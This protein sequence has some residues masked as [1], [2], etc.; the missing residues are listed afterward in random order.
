M[1]RLAL[2]GCGGISHTH[3]QRFHIESNNLKVVAT[4]D[5]DEQAARTAQEHIGAEK[6]ATDY[7]EILDDVDA[8]LLAL[9]HHLHHP[10][11]LECLKAGKHVLMEKPLANTEADCLELI[12]AAEEHKVVL[13]VA[14]C[15]RYHP[16]LEKMHELIAAK[17]YGDTFHVSIWTEQFTKYADDHWAHK[18]ATVG[19]GQFFSHGCHYVDIL[20]LLLGE[21]ERGVH[22]GTNFGTPWMEKEGTSD[23]SITF[24]SGAVGYHGGT[25]GARGSRLGNAFHAHC[26]E[27]ML[28]ADIDGGELRLLRWGQEPEILLKTEECSKYM[29]REMHHFIDCI[30]NGIEPITDA[31]DSLQ[32]LRVVWK[33]YEAEEKHTMADLN[34]LGI[35]H[36]RNAVLLNPASSD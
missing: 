28:E 32:G 27:G 3:A 24:K 29:D 23:V 16:I 17:T 4:V 13:M 8:V 30:E 5:I 20:L 21:P 11:G 18:I 31:Y 15:M 6:W 35:K 12:A 2:I 10:V 1:V 34:G 36:R 9:P 25:W 26:T 7:R 22:V 14:Y 33:L 19:G